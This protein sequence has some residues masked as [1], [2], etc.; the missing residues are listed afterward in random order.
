MKTILLAGA[1]ALAA[2]PLSAQRNDLGLNN[3]TAGEQRRAYEN[4]SRVRVQNVLTEFESAWGSR[5][6]AALAA[7]Y[8]A[9]ANLYPAGRALVT[10]RPAIR[11]YLA[12]VLPSA[13]P[14]RTRIMEFHVSGDIA[15]AAVQVTPEAAPRF[16]ADASVTHIFVFRS[17]DAG[18]WM[19][20]SH[21]TRP[22]LPSAP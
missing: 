14:I 4:E 13:L 3:P 15:F 21:L 9:D 1:L 12:A 20:V 2:A 7:M 16:V 6:T 19:I 5:D 10:G 8:A 17:D 11:E 22:E 18:R